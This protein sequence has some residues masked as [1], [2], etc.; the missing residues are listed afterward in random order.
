MLLSHDGELIMASSAKKELASS[1]ETGIL[2]VDG[3]V[4]WLYGL[5]GG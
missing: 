4:N 1:S 2:K 3:K 5:G